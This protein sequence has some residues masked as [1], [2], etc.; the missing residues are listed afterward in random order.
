MLMNVVHPDLMNF[1]HVSM[2]ISLGVV[3]GESG[4]FLAYGVLCKRILKV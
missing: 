4:P 2:I 3:S 1:S